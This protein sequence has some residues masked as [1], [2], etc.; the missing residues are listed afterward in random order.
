MHEF[1]ERVN[2]IDLT[3]MAVAV[4]MAVWWI[5]DAIPLFAT[6]LLP[7]VL[8]PLMGILTTKATAPIYINSMIFLF[9][10]SFMIA[11]TMEN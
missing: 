11:L 6:A 2:F 4:L 3:R 9:M 1:K 10:G 7:M 5:T 8:Y